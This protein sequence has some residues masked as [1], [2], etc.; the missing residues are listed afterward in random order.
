VSSY[1]LE[2]AIA[3]IHSTSKTYQATDWK[4]IAA[5][6]GQLLFR[7]PNPF[8]ELN[9]GI[10]LYYAGQKQFAFDVLHK[11]QKHPF[12]SQYYP[13]HAALG[14]FYFLEGDFLQAKNC[15]QKAREQTSFEKEKNY[16][17][18]QIDLL[19]V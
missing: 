4:T 7:Y 6:Y 17:Q 11:L 14:K 5:L 10:A 15:L 3:R 9:Y 2:A 19:E 16:I 13:L 1:H 12:I 8:A 18:A